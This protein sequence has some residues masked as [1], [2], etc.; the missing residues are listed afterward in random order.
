MSQKRLLARFA[1]PAVL[2]GAVLA[3]ALVGAIMLAALG[4]NPWTA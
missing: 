3:A 2:I 4:A 1:G